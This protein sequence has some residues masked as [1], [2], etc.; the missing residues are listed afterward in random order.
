MGIIRIEKELQA[1]PSPE[2]KA[3][4]RKLLSKPKRY[5]AG[6]M[7][8]AVIDGNDDVNTNIAQILRVMAQKLETVTVKAVGHFD[9]EVVI[10]PTL[11]SLAGLLLKEIKGHIL[12]SDLLDKFSMSP[13]SET[14]KENSDNKM[15]SNHQKSSDKSV[16]VSS[17]NETRGGSLPTISVNGRPLPNHVRFIGYSGGGSVA[18][19]CAMLLDGSLNITSSIPDTSNSNALDSYHL[20]DCMDCIGSF[21]DRV[22]CVTLGSPPC[23]SRT[24]VPRYV[25]SIICGD[26]IVVRSYPESIASLRKRVKKALKMGAGKEGLSA[27][28]GW[29]L[30]AGWAKD[31]AS[32][33][34]QSLGKYSGI[35]L[36]IFKKL[37]YIA[38]LLIVICVM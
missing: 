18:A 21:S 35:F 31:F 12:P 24:L 10:Q 13:K 20:R 22:R 26:D 7:I 33:A 3:M 15:F 34:G 6:E 14:T 23:I 17:N 11:L 5:L 28:L 9:Q 2:K 30:G 25:T 8:I 29:V 37:V 1:N 32:I 27:N 36:E 4:L 38:Y 16:Y 19:Y